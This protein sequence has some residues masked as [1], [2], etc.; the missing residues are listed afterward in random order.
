MDPSAISNREPRWPPWRVPAPREKKGVVTTAPKSLG[1]AFLWPTRRRPLRL[2][3]PAVQE[4]VSALIDFLR[5]NPEGVFTTAELLNQTCL[6]APQLSD[7]LQTLAV[8]GVVAENQSGGL[9]RWSLATSGGRRESSVSSPLRTFYTVRE[10]AELSG[11]TEKAVRRRIE[12]GTL[13]AVREGRAVLVSHSALQMAG[14][15]DRRRKRSRAAIGA[16]TAIDLLKRGR[17]Q[18]S[19]FQLSGPTGLRRQR[20]ETVMATLTA[21]GLTR[22]EMSGGIVW[23]WNDR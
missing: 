3:P 6:S 18:M 15:V 8:A 19:A 11:L 12:R 23:R 9:R 4:C 20:V 2:D 7:V 21:V 5:L 17:E 1:G 22:R 14:L 10:A 13:L 16:Q